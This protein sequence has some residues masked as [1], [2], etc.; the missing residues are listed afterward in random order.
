MQEAKGTRVWLESE[1]QEARVV[2]GLAARSELP[3]SISS[4]RSLKLNSHE[5]QGW[6]HNITGMNTL[7]K[8][9]AWS[10]LDLRVDGA[11]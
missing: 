10:P 8:L 9:E 3:F 11:R 2:A 4:R 6:Q 5:Q 7:R 1:V